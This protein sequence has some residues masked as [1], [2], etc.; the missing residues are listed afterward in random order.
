LFIVLPINNIKIREIRALI[1]VSGTGQMEGQLLTPRPTITILVMHLC[2]MLF[3]HIATKLYNQ[4]A[5][6]LLVK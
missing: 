6:V 5:F 2:A 3:S 4:H 1:L